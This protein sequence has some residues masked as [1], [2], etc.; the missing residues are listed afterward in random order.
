MVSPAVNIHKGAGHHGVVHHDTVHHETVHVGS[1]VHHGAVHHETVHV[2][3]PVHHGAAHH[4]TVHHETV[5]V[6]SPVHR[7]AHHQTVHHETVHVGSPVHHGAVHHETVHV[8]SPVHHGAAHH[9]TVHETVHVGSPVHHGAHH[10]TVH[11][12]TVHVG[13]PVHHGAV[14]HETVHVGSPVHHSAVHHGTVHHTGVVG[15]T[16]LAPSGLKLHDDH[17]E[18]KHIVITNGWRDITPSSRHGKTIQKSFGVDSKAK[19]IHALVVNHCLALRKDEAHLEFI[20]EDELPDVHTK[21]EVYSIC[22]SKHVNQ[23]IVHE[24]ASDPYG[25]KKILYL[26]DYSMWTEPQVRALVLLMHASLRADGMGTGFAD[27]ANVKS[28]EC[29]AEHYCRT[30][31]IDR[32]ELNHLHTTTSPTRVSRVEVHGIKHLEPE[33]KYYG[34]SVVPK[35][36]P[37]VHRQDSQTPVKLVHTTLDHQEH[38][39]VDQTVIV[40]NNGFRKVLSE[41]LESDDLH[42]NDEELKRIITGENEH[43]KTVITTVEDETRFEKDAKAHAKA[44][45]KSQKH[46]QSLHSAH[47]SG[48]R[49]NDTYTI[50]SVPDLT[51]DHVHITPVLTA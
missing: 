41:R 10:Q 42:C 36:D 35:R 34:R 43:K 22:I 26:D 29:F 25:W 3:S 32:A 38:G 46:H 31:G 7:G 16:V 20:S 12:E 30:V 17:V 18:Q 49:R 11:H 45:K 47:V 24:N 9:Q 23:A 50:H 1:P 40:T 4:Q 8:G 27:N 39:G 44:Q 5:H 51:H 48:I 33:R 28:A 19:K 2:G 37:V 21:H 15:S 13:S 6:G 14:H